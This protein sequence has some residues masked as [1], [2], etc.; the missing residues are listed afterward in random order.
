MGINE[1]SRCSSPFAKAAPSNQFVNW[2]CT[3]RGQL[4]YCHF[5]RGLQEEEEKTDNEQDDCRLYR[6]THRWVRACVCVCAWLDWQ[7]EHAT[8]SLARL[9]R[10]PSIRPGLSCCFWLYVQRSASHTNKRRFVRL[11]CA[12][13]QPIDELCDDVLCGSLCYLKR[14]LLANAVALCVVNL[15][16]YSVQR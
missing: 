11:L 9:C 2:A 14:W 6:C 12:F 8:R 5:H 10:A 1:C 3:E 13:L 4:V 7:I 15:C 16:T